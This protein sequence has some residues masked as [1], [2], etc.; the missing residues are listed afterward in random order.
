MNKNILR[1]SLFIQHLRIV[2]Y[3]KKNIFGVK[4]DHLDAVTYNSLENVNSVNKS[5]VHFDKLIIKSEPS[6]KAIFELIKEN[7]LQLD[8]KKIA[9]VG[10]GPGLLLN[11]ID[12]SYKNT[13]L[14]G[15]DYADSKIIHSKEKF[16][17]IQF[18]VYDIF[19]S[20]L[21]K[22]DFVFCT[23]VLEHLVEPEL[24]LKNLIKMLQPKGSLLLTVPNG[25]LD[26]FKGHIHF[27]SPESWEIF[28]MK[29]CGNEQFNVGTYNN[30]LNNYAIITLN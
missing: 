27:W 1:L 14:I 23:E 22:A 16:P 9:D 21:I 7:K 17:N 28:I 29:I 13:E 20:N 11:L 25:R 10:C 24:A 30:N 12:K 2:K 19:S 15:L 4:Q 26:T 5:R 8:N 6:V 18:Q 3:L